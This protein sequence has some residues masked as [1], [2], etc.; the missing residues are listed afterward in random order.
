[1]HRTKRTNRTRLTARLLAACLL[2]LLCSGCATQTKK[3]SKSG[4]YFDTIITITLYG[5]EDSAPIDHCFALAA[6]YEHKFSAARADSE[7]SQINAHA[8]QFV[9]VSSDTL[10]LIQ[11]GIRYG[12][13]SGGKFDI[14]V[15]RLSKL[16]NIPEIAKNAKDEN[17]KAAPSVLP[18]AGEIEEARSHVDYH[19]IV[20]DQNQV[21]LTDPDTAIDLGGI[22]KGYI[23]DRMRE[24]LRGENITAGIIDLGG[25]LLTLGEKADHARYTIGIQKPFADRGELLGTLKV[26]DASVVSSGI[27]ERYFRVDGRLYH[28]ILD[29][30]TGYPVQND[31]TQVTI[32]SASSMDGDALSTACFALGLTDGLTLVESMDGVEAL[33]VTA[34]GELHFSTGFENELTFE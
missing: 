22:A 16:W 19:N 12:E 34:D 28:H 4:F 2:F 3:V 24:Y 9:E 14:T 1:M 11:A 30:D 32:V 10:E 21:M 20:I 5:T 26:K 7:I 29:V 18:E 6:E 17:N 13:L 31:L 27:Y 25:N 33:F 23:A 15:G 8:G